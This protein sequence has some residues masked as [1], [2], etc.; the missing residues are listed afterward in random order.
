LTA[1]TADNIFSAA[2]FEGIGFTAAGK[3]FVNRVHG[4][5]VPSASV[6][7]QSIGQAMGLFQTLSVT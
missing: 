3:T 5:Y 6:A 2:G 7:F 1:R 4:N